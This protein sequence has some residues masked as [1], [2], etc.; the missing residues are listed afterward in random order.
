M[1]ED[2]IGPFD[3]AAEVLHEAPKE[4]ETYIDIEDFKKVVAKI[5]KVLS[6]EPVPDSDKLIR[7]ELDFGEG[8]PRQIL[9]GIREWYPEPEKL[10]G[11]QMLFVINLAP[12]KI[13]GLESNG[14]LMAVDGLDGQPVF[15]VPETEVRPGSTVR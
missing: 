12:R 11:K 13:R 7:F 10:V 15:L 2:N 8:Q 3:T 1:N 4:E 5:G 14:M 6:A 9:S